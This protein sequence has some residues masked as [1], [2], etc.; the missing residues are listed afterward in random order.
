MS[1]EGL[2]NTTCN[3][4]KNTRTQSS[5]SGQAT[6]SWAN[7][8]TGVLCRLDEANDEEFKSQAGQYVRASH[9]LFI[10]DTTGGV[11][12]NEAEYRFVIDS[13]NYNILQI[14][15][16]GGQG[17]HKEIMLERIY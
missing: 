13:K 12:I 10:G 6:N 7:V 9:V 4:Q 11:S 5:T 3:I 14:R 2:F 15:D 17:H 1:I 8:A 16:A